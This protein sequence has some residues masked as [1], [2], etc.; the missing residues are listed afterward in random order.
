[1][2]QVFISYKREDEIRVARIARALE[3]AGVE[4]W[5]DRGLPSAESFQVN[6][7]KN[8]DAAGC[9]IVVWSQGS[10]A[11]EG[12]YVRDEARRGLASG[13]LVP[14][15][16]DR[17]KAIPLGFGEIQA[18]D[19]SHWR[20]DARDPAFQDLVEAVR[21]KLAGTPQPKPRGPSARVGRR[22]TYASLS[23]V[24]V[25]VI[26]SLVANLFEVT[27][28]VCTVP[29]LQPALSDACG[30]LAL[31]SRPSKTERLAWAARAPGSCEALKAH[32][33]RFPRG[34][35]REEAVALITARRRSFEDRWTPAT[36]QLVTFTPAEG[37]P[38]AS[39]AAAKTAALQRAR[40]AAD[41]LCR[42]F[43][44]GSLFRY[45]SATA[46][47]ENWSCSANGAGTLCAFD[48]HADCQVQERQQ[49]ETDRCGPG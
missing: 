28:R 16:I 40:I 3:K 39:E 8:L 19:L 44:A 25:V 26:A 43:G 41:R 30:A 37:A 6:I 4:V 31:G 46:Y 10:V 14:V 47:A 7:E 22:L 34:A 38:A 12:A 5:W 13:V 42:G 2:S 29:G 33:N 48:G 36:R 11:P 45:V 35:Y 23:G 32:I 9:V 1:V 18:V 49:V 17:I 20:G 27:T 24:G 15:I 21:A